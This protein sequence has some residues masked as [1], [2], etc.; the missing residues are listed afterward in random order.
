MSS[1][2]KTENQINQIEEAI[3]KRHI[4]YY[5]YKY[6]NNT[7]EIGIGG[8][9]KVFRAN[10]KNSE[11]YLALKS[12]FNLDIAT[13]K[14]LSHELELHRVVDFHDNIIR[15]C[16]IT[17][18]NSKNEIDKSKNYLLVMEYADG[19]S[20]RNYLKKNFSDLTWENKYNLAHQLASAV[21]CLHDEGIVHRDLHSGNV[22]VHQNTIKLSDFGLSK[23]IESSKKKSD[24]CGII[25]YID[26]KKF[27]ATYSLN[28]KSDVYSVGI[29]LWEISSGQQPFY[30][31][32]YDVCLAIKIFKG[33]RETAISGTPIEYTSLYTEC[34]DGEPD[35]RPPIIDVVQRL[36]K[37]I[38]QSNMKIN[39]LNPN[40]NADLTYS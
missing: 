18:L 8:F 13:I 34:W 2:A 22:L 7:E 36:K 14:E 32:A 33:R 25:P 15:F 20:L 28:E 35:N 9:G 6:F 30:D 31:D 37:I 29:L 24:I 26:P 16:G 3:S 27:D 23:R 12:F 40:D 38:T 4:K 10:W 5:E 11:Q 17:K 21:S 1:K 19:G 39:N